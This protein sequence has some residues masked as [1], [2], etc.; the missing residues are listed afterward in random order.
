M[1]FRSGIAGLLYLRF[2]QANLYMKGLDVPVRHFQRLDIEKP[3]DKLLRILKGFKIVDGGEYL[4]A[5]LHR[6]VKRGD[7]P[8]IKRVVDALQTTRA[9]DAFINYNDPDGKTP[10]F[11]A[12]KLGEKRIADYLKSV[13]GDAGWHKD[14]L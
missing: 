2:H 12:V 7:L 8:R 9:P 1:L 6:F 4:G 11:W 3:F 10:Y 14:E 5:S 13:G